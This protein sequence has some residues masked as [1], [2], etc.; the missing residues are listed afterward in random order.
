MLAGALVCHLAGRGYDVRPDADRN[1]NSGHRTKH[2]GAKDRYLPVVT[3]SSPV[4]KP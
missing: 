1:P 4:P 3:T 2:L